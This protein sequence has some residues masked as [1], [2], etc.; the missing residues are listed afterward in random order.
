MS[1]RAGESGIAGALSRYG[2]HGDDPEY[3]DWG[4]EL[5]YQEIYDKD[6]QP[7]G[8]IHDEILWEE[9]DEFIPMDRNAMIRLLK[10]W[11]PEHVDQFADTGIVLQYADGS[12]RSLYEGDIEG[13]YKNGRVKPLKTKGLIGAYYSDA[14]QVAVWGH[15]ISSRTGQRVPMTTNVYDRSENEHS[16]KNQMHSV[17]STRPYRVRT[18]TVANKTGRGVTKTSRVIRRSKPKKDF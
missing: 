7:L 12:T 13:V 16:L 10:D 11:W 3:D 4:E 6:G 1:K 2:G 9:E 15:E 8:F 18:M 5:Y 17:R 14:G